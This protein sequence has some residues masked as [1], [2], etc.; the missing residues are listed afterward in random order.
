MEYSNDIHNLVNDLKEYFKEATD[1]NYIDVVINYDLTRMISRFV[2]DI[3]DNEESY[4]KDKWDSM[5][6]E[7]RGCFYDD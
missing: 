3:V 7:A 2:N 6:D 5:C 4:W 1:R